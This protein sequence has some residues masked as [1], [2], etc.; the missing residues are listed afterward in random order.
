MPIADAGSW[1]FF[2]E[3]LNS[4]VFHNLTTGAGSSTNIAWEKSNASLVFGLDATAS[5]AETCT[6]S[7]LQGFAM[8]IWC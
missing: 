8:L 6:G 3:W 4:G 5:E 1:A 7:L 2:Q